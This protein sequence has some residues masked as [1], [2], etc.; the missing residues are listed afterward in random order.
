M[1]AVV[2]AGAVGSYFGGML[3]RAGEPVTLIGRAAHVETIRAHGLRIESLVWDERI[4]VAASTELADARDAAIVLLCVKA[5]DTAP[6]G[7]ALAGVLAPGTPVVSL[8]NG[9]ENAD[10]L[11]AAGLAAVPAVVY[12]A[13]A[14]AEPGHV[15]HTGRGDL[16]LEAPREA[17]ARARLVEFAATC[18]R[19]GV[20]CVLKDDLAP[21]LWTKLVLNCAFNAVSALGQANYGAI[22][23]HPE[24]RAVVACAV[25]EATGVAIAAGVRLPEGDLLEA[26]WRLAGAMPMATSSTAQDLARGRRTEIDALNGYV[27]RRGREL[28]VA[29]PV[30]QALTALVKLRED[31]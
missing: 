8:Q 7:R 26:T 21:A 13:V 10:L 25:E 19:A 14:I 20:A 5:G 17:P 2:G 31:A 3:A 28:G 1:I 30:N 22:A 9:I 6:V 12:V 23:A 16:I 11:V 27:A 24:A 18:A 29:T 4:A 15:R